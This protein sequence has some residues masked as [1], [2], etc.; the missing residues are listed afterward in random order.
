M[1]Q[2][3]CSALP[4]QAGSLSPPAAALRRRIAAIAVSP[5]HT[6]RVRAAC[7]GFVRILFKSPLM[8]L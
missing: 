3:Q 5:A 8:V 7:A 2:P 1:L 4:Y 6:A